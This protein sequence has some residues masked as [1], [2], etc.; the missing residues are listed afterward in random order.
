MLLR[1]FSG[2]A[3]HKLLHFMYGLFTIVLAQ[4]EE[5]SKK[6]S[7]WNGRFNEG[8]LVEIKP[9]YVHTIENFIEVTC[10]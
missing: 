8:I 9:K 2:F 10:T 4:G 7:N 1:I 3:K 6:T 5:I